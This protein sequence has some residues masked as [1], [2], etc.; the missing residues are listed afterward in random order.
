VQF[1]YRNLRGDDDGTLDVLAFY[2]FH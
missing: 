1:I 2:D